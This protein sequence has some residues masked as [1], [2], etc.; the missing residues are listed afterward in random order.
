MSISGIFKKSLQFGVCNAFSF[1]SSCVNNECG[2]EQHAK[3]DF[4]HKLGVLMRSIKCQMSRIRA[5]SNVKKLDILTL[6]CG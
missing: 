5:G 6:F 1:V 4:K 2:E 3:T